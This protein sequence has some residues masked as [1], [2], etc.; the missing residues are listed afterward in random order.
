MF[1]QNKVF[2]LVH[3]VDIVSLS[4]PF[5]VVFNIFFY[6]GKFFFFESI[7]EHVTHLLGK[8]SLGKKNVQVTYVL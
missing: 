3:C 6:M 7:Q 1:S 8:G 2:F 5:L 4:H